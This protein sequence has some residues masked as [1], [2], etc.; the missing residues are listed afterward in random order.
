MSEKS[1]KI[2]DLGIDLMEFTEPYEK[3]IDVLFGSVFN[4]EQRGWIDWYLYER[5]GFDGKEL[6]AYKTVGK[7]KVR[8]CHTIDS[9]WD[10]IQEY[11]K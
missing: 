3:I 9:L 1:R 2:Y 6:K 7:K 5:I 4:S 8:I 10:T 11:K